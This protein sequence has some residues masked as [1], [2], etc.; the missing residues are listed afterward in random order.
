MLLIWKLNR[1]RV[2]KEKYSSASVLL[3]GLGF[4]VLFFKCIM[5][6]ED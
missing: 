3:V 5:L 4:F 2:Y 1:G 6:L